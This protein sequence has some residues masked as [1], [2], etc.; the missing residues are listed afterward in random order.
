[1]QQADAAGDR[2]TQIRGWTATQSYIRCER[3]VQQWHVGP[4]RRLSLSIRLH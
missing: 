1:M 2:I 3:K 4:L